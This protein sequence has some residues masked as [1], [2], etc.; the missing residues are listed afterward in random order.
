MAHPFRLILVLMAFLGLA[1]PVKAQT[2]AAAIASTATAMARDNELLWIAV[3]R[4]R[5]TAASG[6]TSPMGSRR[7]RRGPRLIDRKMT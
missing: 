5:E 2:P 6:S 1:A 3:V 7:V 4:A